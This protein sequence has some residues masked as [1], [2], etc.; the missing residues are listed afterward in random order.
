MWEPGIRICLGNSGHQRC[1]PMCATVQ[2]FFNATCW[3]EIH[4]SQKPTRSTTRCQSMVLVFQ[5][6]PFKDVWLWVVH[7]AALPMQK[8]PFSID[9]ACWWRCVCWQAQVLGKTVFTKAE[10]EVHSEFSSFGRWREFNFLFET[11]AGESWPW[12][13]L[14]PW[15]KHWQAGWEFRRP[16]W[17]GAHTTCGMWCLHSASWCVFKPD[18]PWC[19]CLQICSWGFALLG[20]RQT[21]SL[22]LRQKELSAKMAQPTVT[23]LQRLKNVMGY[24]KGTSTYAVVIA[25]PD[26]GQ[27]KRKNTNEPFWVLESASDSG[28]SSNKE[29]RR[30]TSAGI[31]LI[32]GF[33]MFGS[34]RT[35]RTVNLSSCEAELHAMVSTLADGIY[36][37]RCLSFLTQA[38]VSHYLMTDSSSARQL[39]SK[40]G[41]GKIRHLD[42]KILW[43]QQHVLSGDVFLAATSNGL[44]RCRSMHKVSTSTTS[45]CLASWAKRLQGQWIDNHWTAW[46]WWASWKA[47]LKATGHAV[48]K[49]LD[50]CFFCDGPWVNWCKRPNSFRW[51][52]GIYM[53]HWSPRP[54]QCG[55]NSINGGEQ[56]SQLC[57]HFCGFDHMGHFW[58]CKLQ[59]IGC[60]R[61]GSVEWFF[62]RN[63]ITI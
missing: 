23:A 8:W 41:V 4:H 59:A 19:L 33:Y 12:T 14:G 17:P 21:R 26:G 39:A 24:V 44:E 16:L 51:T 15:N 46:T 43:A 52:G 58:M 61:S 60:T 57:L 62:S 7:R 10:G 31:H 55:S 45:E 50:A 53:C 29:H 1:P 48:S 25:E 5:G 38:D 32:L 3:K 9:V 54:M 40:Q 20:K 13:G 22:V 11:K 37:K 28:W 2:T 27:G 30:S 42:G 63:K 49:E 56:S 35:Q 6:A 18:I 36:I 47:W 34:L